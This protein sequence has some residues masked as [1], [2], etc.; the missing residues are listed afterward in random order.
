MS[1]VKTKGLK[2]L[3]QQVSLDD[4]GLLY[5]YGLFE[6]IKVFNGVPF[7]FED[8]V[9]RLKN[10][11]KC[12]YFPNTHVRALKSLRQTVYKYI[13]KNKITAGGVRLSITFGN[14]R[15]DVAPVLIISHRAIPY[16]KSQYRL[17]FSI[18][19][20]SVKK[21]ESSRLV[22]HKT[23][24]YLENIISARVCL[25]NKTDDSL[26][27]N[28][29]GFIAECG[30][31]NIFFIKSGRAFTPS[32]KCGILPGVTRGHIKALLN[33][34]G[35]ETTEGKFKL[36]RLLQSDECFVTNSMLGIMPVT[37]VGGRKIGMGKPG[38]FTISAMNNLEQSV[39]RYCR[40]EGMNGWL[41]ST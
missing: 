8:H 10:S 24:N 26:F 17:G 38:V 6:T 39:K 4:Y 35:V 32:L 5:G 19:V 18:S 14:P 36:D 22:C 41:S 21:N 16:T 33:E 28:T 25:D 37:L 9:A 31:S 7:L 34:M 29:S 1:R 12:L 27:L 2:L 40:S 3:P 30:Y 23:F 11:M 13:L 20:S 15:H